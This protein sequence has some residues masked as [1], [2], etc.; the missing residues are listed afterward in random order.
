M[1]HFSVTP[2][3]I[4]AEPFHHSCRKP[5]TSTVS[6]CSVRYLTFPGNMGLSSAGIFLYA[7]LRHLRR[8]HREHRIDMIHAHG[9]LP[10]GQAAVMLGHELEIPFV[11]SV[12]GLDT[13]ATNQVRG[14]PG[15]WCESASRKVYRA[16]RCIM[17]V[18]ESV[19]RQLARGMDIGDVDCHVVYNGADPLV[20]SP[21]VS[22]RDLSEVILSVGNLDV[23]KGHELVLRAVHALR[24]T[25]PR[26]RYEIVGTGPQMPRL[27]A[28]ARELGIAERVVLLGRRSRQEVAS[29]MRQCI[30]FVLPSCY[31]ALG[32]VYLEAMASAKPAIGCKEQ[33]IAEIIRHG[34]NG[35]LMTPGSLPELVQGLSTLLDNPALRQ[36]LGNEG[37]RT[38][39]EGHT[40][41]HQAANWAR[42]YREY[43]V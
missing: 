27:A 38:V 21:T 30:V 1:P 4:V 35:W 7:Q 8:L 9:A 15:R 2:T 11:V 40:L 25:H 14:L 33:G 28:L 23:I 43:I 39:L 42:I 41:T 13:F 6:A 5:L 24:N 16:A 37:R 32:C 36:Q 22:E 19:R 18:S 31:E 3:V 17:C 10:C 26:L 20:F 29:K 12:H 34:E